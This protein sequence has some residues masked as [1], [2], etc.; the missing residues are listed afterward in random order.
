MPPQSVPFQAGSQ[1]LLQILQPGQGFYVPVY[2][3]SYTWGVGQIDRL[4]EDINDG[5]NRAARA[6]GPPTFLGSM[7]LFEG[8]GSVA[9]KVNTAL[10][11][12]VVSDQGNPSSVIIENRHGVGV[13]VGGW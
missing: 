4:F 11:A 10:P 13:L 6:P 3:R 12:Q 7:I 2:Q 1:T 5:L 8:R 9:P